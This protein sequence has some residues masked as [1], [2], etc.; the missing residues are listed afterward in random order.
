MTETRND[1]QTA[2]AET[3]RLLKQ[4]LSEHQQ[5]RLESAERLYRLILEKYPGQED[6]LHFLG[7]LY[8]QFG[9]TE[10]SLR[11]LRQATDSAPR[12]PDILCNLGLVLN[13]ARP[14]KRGRSG[15]RA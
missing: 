8:H 12:N 10:E 9:R 14:G 5:G 4:A 3:I 13:A 15:W 7:V 1:G 2:D 6:A 11:F